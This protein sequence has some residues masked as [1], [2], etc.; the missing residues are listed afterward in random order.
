MNLTPPSPAASKSLWVKNRSVS[1]VFSARPS[2][3]IENA[4]SDIS[5]WLMN[6]YWIYRLSFK[7]FATGVTYWS[8]R[9]FLSKFRFLNGSRLNKFVRVSPLIL[10]LSISILLKFDLFLRTLMS[11]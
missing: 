6:I 4:F 8:V 7:V 10:L 11:S 1:L 5:L 9:A 3:S 2:L